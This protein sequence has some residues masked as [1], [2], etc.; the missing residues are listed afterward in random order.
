MRSTSGL[1]YISNGYVVGPISWH[2]YHHHAY[3]APK[4]A[5]V[6]KGPPLKMLGVFPETGGQMEN[7]FPSERRFA[8]NLPEM[9][10]NL[11]HT[12]KPGP[13]VYAF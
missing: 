5:P 9:S 4:G 7:R 2:K 10:F 12:E 1:A 3:E 8:Q 11:P 13:I 6:N